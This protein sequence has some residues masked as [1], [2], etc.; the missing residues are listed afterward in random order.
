MVD[1]TDTEEATTMDLT[2]E[3]HLLEHLTRNSSNQIKPTKPMDSSASLSRSHGLRS[4]NRWARVKAKARAGAS[5]EEP[6]DVATSKSG[7]S[8]EQ[9]LLTALRRSCFSI[10]VRPKCLRSK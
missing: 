4:T 10:Q 3:D 6:T 8:R 7:E 2:E 1:H 5:G 9:R